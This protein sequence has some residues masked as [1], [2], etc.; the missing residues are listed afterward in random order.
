VIEIDVHERAT[1]ETRGRGRELLR[2][3]VTEQGTVRQLRERI[4]MRLAVQ[5][6]IARAV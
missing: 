5:T 3:P 6:L 1:R 2:Q 4:E